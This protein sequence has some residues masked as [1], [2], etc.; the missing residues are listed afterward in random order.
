MTLMGTEDICILHNFYFR[1]NLA[2]VPVTMDPH[3]TFAITGISLLSV[4]H[5]V[6]VNVDD[7]ASRIWRSCYCGI[8][9]S[10]FTSY[11]NEAN[12]FRPTRF[13]KNFNHFR[14]LLKICILL[15]YQTSIF[16]SQNRLNNDI[17]FSWNIHLSIFLVYFIK[18]DGFYLYW[19]GES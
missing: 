16:I 2:L 13:E 9:F 6:Q 5:V 15:I 19:I 14:F 1:F 11:Y 17:I 3:F 7:S 4:E 12:K 10:C 8:C 18:S